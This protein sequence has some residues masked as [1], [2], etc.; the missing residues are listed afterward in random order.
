MSIRK[1]RGS[2]ASTLSGKV[3]MSLWAQCHS[4]HCFPVCAR[5]LECRLSADGS[6]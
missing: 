4:G 6:V 3:A 2:E 1:S 5:C